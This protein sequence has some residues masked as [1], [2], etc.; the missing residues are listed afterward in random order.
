MYLRFNN[1]VALVSYAL[2]KSIRLS[3][4]ATTRRQDLTDLQTFIS[5]NTS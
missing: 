2:Y 1:V 4:I 3:Q 5:I